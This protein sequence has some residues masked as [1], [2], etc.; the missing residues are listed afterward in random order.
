[1]TYIFTAAQFVEKAKA[2]AK[3]YKTLYVMGCFGAPMNATNKKRYS[4]N[5]PYNRKPARQKLI[6]DASS[7]TFGFDC[8]CLIKGLLWGWSGNLHATYGGAVYG[9]NGV[10]DVDA[11]QMMKYCTSVSKDFS[12][13]EAGEVVH[14]SGH[15]GIYIGNG[16]V[17]ECTP[18]W[19]DGVQITACGNIGK[20]RG[21][22]TRTWTNHGKLK[23][24]NYGGG[25][26]PKKKT[27]DELAN[28]V[29]E[30]KWKNGSERKR[31]LT[32]AYN[33]G[34]IGYTYA[35]VQDRVDEICAAKK[36]TYYVVKKGD[37]LSHIAHRYHTTIQQILKLNAGIRNPNLITIGQKIRV[38]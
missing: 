5:S 22:N 21:Y 9:S 38:K 36:A 20:K 33:K 31:L 10:P 37:T 15:I 27:L 12:H 1:M 7:D 3:N 2:V 11:D 17:V 16:L 29:I 24:I 13:I 14:M 32:D 34:E 8:I 18:I 19:K 6:M 26:T 35:Q 28:E 23:F 30:G 25:T 4:K